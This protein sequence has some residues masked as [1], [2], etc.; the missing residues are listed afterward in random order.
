MLYIRSWVLNDGFESVEL[1][2]S[3][4]YARFIIG[5][6]SWESKNTCTQQRMQNHIDRQDDIGP[7]QAAWAMKYLANMTYDQLFVLAE[8][9]EDN[10]DLLQKVVEAYWKGIY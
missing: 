6:N 1:K 5:R 3:R 7:N 9:C 10:P 4:D 8:M 2:G